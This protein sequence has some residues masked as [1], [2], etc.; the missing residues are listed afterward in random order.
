[1]LVE[2]DGKLLEESKQRSIDVVAGTQSLMVIVILA[3]A[4]VVAFASRLFAV[5]RFESI[6]HEFDPWYGD[7][8][9]RLKGRAGINTAKRVAVLVESQSSMVQVQLSCHIPYGD[10]RV[11]SLPELVRQASVVSIGTHCWRD[12]KSPCFG[13]K[14]GG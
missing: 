11:L 13:G 6:I 14:E 5:I 7:G 4:C 12:G 1:M 10:E 9:V 2:T 3:L 8:G